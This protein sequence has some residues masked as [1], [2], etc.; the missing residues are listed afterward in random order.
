M[1]S[2]VYTR[3]GAPE[4]L[5][6]VEK[7]KPVPKE[8]E[9]L[10]RIVA[11]TVTSGDARMR[12][13]RVPYGFGLLSRL[14]LGITGPRTHV[15]GYEL[16]GVI[17][18]AG[19]KV[20]AFQPGDA[21]F[22]FTGL[23]LGAYAEY[24]CL[25]ERG[26]L[27]PKPSSVSFAEAAAIP[28]GGLTALYFLRNKG[29]IQPGQK[30]LIN[31]ASGAVGTAA[32]QLAKHFG[33]E[34]TGVSSGANAPL[35]RSLGADHV[36]DYEREDFTKSGK[37]YDIILE[38]VGVRSFPECRQALAKNGRYLFVVGD[39]AQYWKSFTSSL[40]GGKR[41]LGGLTPE[42]EEDLQF[43]ATLLET[44]KLKATI[45]RTFPL[46]QIVDAHRYVDAGHKKGVV[47]ISVGEK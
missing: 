17:E 27:L 41:A 29:Q 11:T 10:V 28:F 9:V 7:E 32:V 31:G 39:A 44:G 13:L 3:Y 36:I 34:V 19:A 38:T 33:A 37:T 25:P 15:L 6:L 22:G 45:D 1:K 40:A 46:S 14:A 16:S 35:V 12:A 47:V 21:V 2:V 5:N 18:A 8:N 20:T 43:L 30:V 4:V 24:R 42:K 26:R 23:G